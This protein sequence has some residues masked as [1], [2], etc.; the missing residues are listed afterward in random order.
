MRAVVGDLTEGIEYKADIVVANLLA[1]LV[2]KLTSSV[3]KHMADDAVYIT[4]GILVDK[5]LQV[6]SCLVENGLRILEILQDGEWC[7]IAAKRDKC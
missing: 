3:A 5:E 1:D 2:I 6:T 4:S 7:S